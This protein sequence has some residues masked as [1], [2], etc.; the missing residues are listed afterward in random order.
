MAQIT[1]SRPSKPAW[2]NVY[3]IGKKTPRKLGNQANLIISYIAT[4]GMLYRVKDALLLHLVRSKF[5]SNN[6]KFDCLPHSAAHRRDR[7][8]NGPHFEA[9]TRP[10]PDIYFWSPI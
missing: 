7:V 8:V 5:I 10:E 3:L 6:Q 4:S 9:R 1:E 2:R